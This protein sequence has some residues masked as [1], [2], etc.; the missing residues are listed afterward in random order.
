MP[1]TGKNGA[2][3]KELLPKHRGDPLVTLQ[4]RTKKQLPEGHKVPSHSRD[5]QA[6]QG[7]Q[8]NQNQ[9][10]MTPKSSTK[11]VDGWADPVE[12]PSEARSERPDLPTAKKEDEKPKA[13]SS[14]SLPFQ[15]LREP[16]QLENLGAL[17]QPHKEAV[18]EPKDR[19]ATIVRREQRGQD[20]RPT[21]SIKLGENVS[22]V[23]RSPGGGAS[24]EQKY[25][26]D[27][28]KAS[29]GRDYHAYKVAYEKYLLAGRR[30]QKRVEVLSRAEDSSYLK[31]AGKHRV[32]VQHGR[33]VNGKPTVTFANEEHDYKALTPPSH[34]K[35]QPYAGAI[36]SAAEQYD[37]T[38]FFTLSPS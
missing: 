12:A 21:G 28:E 19:V 14:N 27:E 23:P 24:L 34:K 30:Y 20:Q 11:G 31:Y 17:R 13:E 35:L 26:S 37:F 10:V 8:P 29:M 1:R 3:K 22:A 7:K 25:Q 18:T 5:L 15:N 16:E 9:A 32:K 36:I 6:P 33:R 4:D 38:P 2:A